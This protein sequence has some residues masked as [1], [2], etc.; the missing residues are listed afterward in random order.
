MSLLPESEKFVL[1]F[2]SRHLSL[3]GSYTLDLS[4]LGDPAGSRAVA[5]LAL[6]V[7]SP[8]STASWR[9]HSK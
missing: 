5:G 9:Y 4:S 8:F 1:E 2:N 3:S 7:T 6:G